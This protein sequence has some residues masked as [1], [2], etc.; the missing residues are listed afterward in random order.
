MELT[1]VLSNK[2][3]LEVMGVSRSGRV[4]K[5][6]S[7]LMDFQSPDDIE[8]K[9]KK[10]T[11]YKS[12]QIMR[13]QQQQQ[14]HLHQN[15]QMSSPGSVGGGDYV[16]MEANIKMEP[17]LD[18]SV[19]NIGNSDSVDDSD[20]SDGD[21]VDDIGG[22]SSNESIDPVNELEEFLHNSSPLVK[23][24]ATADMIQPKRSLYMSE[25]S[26]KRI[27]YS[28]DGNMTITKPHRKDKGKSRF[29]AY[30]LWA[31]EV[32]QDMMYSHPELDFSSI[33][34]RLGEMWANVPS[35][36]KYNWKRRAKR[37][38]AKGKTLGMGLKP[39]AKRGDAIATLSTKFINKDVTN[40]NLK[41]QLESSDA[42]SLVAAPAAA[43]IR[44][45]IAAPSNSSSTSSTKTSPTGSA[46]IYRITGQQPADIAAYLKLLGD[47][48]TIIGERLKEHE[49]QITV[50]GSLSVL[51]D[52]ILCS[53]GPLMCL[54]SHI[55]NL[56]EQS[57]A[58]K[59]HLANILDN[60][61]YVMPGL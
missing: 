1:P 13:Q 4:R 46:G 14:Q 50:S 23:P 42:S 5:K 53:I 61:A 7:K 16:A 19:E 12:S 28:K 35:G 2:G 3:D 56:G 59:E 41:S 58:T 15:H 10:P 49:G 54:T 24:M 45:Q 22:M 26:R 43:K 36:E 20:E 51:L 31:K 37:L 39:V 48:L 8:T 52:S 27:V 60:I 38:A 11:V 30:M 9:L 6:S 29:T 32:R 47:N 18:L 25:K 55:P 17:D 33:S 44:H 57:D 34:K 40:K 21:L